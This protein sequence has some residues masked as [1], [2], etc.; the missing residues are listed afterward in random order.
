MPSAETNGSIQ[1]VAVLGAGT[2]GARL[3]AHIANAGFP[4]LLLDLAPQ[5][6]ADRNAL[7][8]R[9]VENLKK[10]KP[11][12]FVD[13][14]VVRNITIGNFDDDLEKLKDCDW[15]LEAVAENLDIKRAL[16]DKIAPYVHS[17]AIVTTNTSGL[18]V[19]LIAKDMHGA[20]GRR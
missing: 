7:A 1:K 9:A 10:A 16:L 3:A 6:T 18:P 13:P 20:F 12:A 19:G 8:S 14:T 15:I 11:P 4:V 2:M 17:S 5:A